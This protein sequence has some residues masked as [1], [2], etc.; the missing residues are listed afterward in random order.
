MFTNVILQYGAVFV[1]LGFAMAVYTLQFAEGWRAVVG[2]IISFF[3]FI[4][5][6]VAFKQAMS[7][8][9]KEDKNS[10]DKFRILLAEIKKINSKLGGDESGSNNKSD[11]KL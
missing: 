8:A 5:G 4:L 2:M 10:K 1:P 7:M 3:F 11:T 6:M 9:R